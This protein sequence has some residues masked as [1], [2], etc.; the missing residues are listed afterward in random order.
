MTIFAPLIPSDDNASGGI[1]HVLEHWLMM[2][3][4]HWSLS[5]GFIYAYLC[6]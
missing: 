6:Y 5:Q 4:E 3:S 2:I 1:E